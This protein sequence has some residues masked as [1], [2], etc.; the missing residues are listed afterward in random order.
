MGAHYRMGRT[1]HQLFIAALSAIYVLRDWKHVLVLVTA[2]T[3]GHS[4][5]LALSVT[6]VVRFSSLG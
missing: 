6:D 5:T 1:D 3:L 4:L 2:F